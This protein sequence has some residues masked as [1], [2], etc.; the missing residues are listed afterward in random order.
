MVGSGMD[1][2]WERYGMCELAFIQPL[3]SYKRKCL[4][5]VK[6][7]KKLTKPG[8]LLILKIFEKNMVISV[9]LE[10]KS[11]KICLKFE[12]TLFNPLMVE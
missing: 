12:V 1:T 5:P 8:L 7:K 2:A 3:N 6:K 11:P 10:G 4:C 9:F